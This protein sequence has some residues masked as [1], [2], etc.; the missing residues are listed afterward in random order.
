MDPVAAEK[1]A[2][3]DFIEKSEE[4][5][6][7][8][9]PD[10]ISQEQA[11]PLGRV[12]LAFANTSAQY[13]RI[14][15]KAA[16]DL[17]NRRGSDKENISKILYYSVVQN[18]A[19]NAL[20]Q[21]IFAVAFGDE[22]EDEGLLDDKKLNVVNGMLDSVIRGAGIAGAVLSIV[23][24]AGLKIYK[25]TEKENPKYENM[26]FEAMKISPPISSKVSKIRSAGRTMSWDMKEIKA[27]GLDITNPAIGAGAQV[28]SATTNL[29]LDRVIRKIENLKAASDSELE[30]YKRLAL[31][32]G[33]GKWE[34][35]IKDEKWK[36]PNA[37]PKSKSKAKGPKVRKVKIRR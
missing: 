5:Q 4:S 33:W 37:K 11:G 2:M 14:T 13:T 23:K 15:K 1:A 24:N 18:L 12:I 35:G 8:S 31:A 6:Q 19:F 7:S 25:E 10:K 16:S 30:T 20:Q 27:K 22:E 3:R 34:L 9:R 17:I 36:D 21:A 29:P 28:I 26:V 32:L